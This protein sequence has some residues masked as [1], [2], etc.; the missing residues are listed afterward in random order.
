MVCGNPVK[1]VFEK[2]GHDGGEIVWP[3]NP[4]PKN[5]RGFGLNEMIMYGHRWG[6][7]F[8]PVIPAWPLTQGENDTTFFATVPEWW[9]DMMFMQHDGVLIGKHHAVA[10]DSKQQ[11]ILDPNGTKYP[12]HMFSME[13][14]WARTN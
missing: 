14:F 6:V 11:L 8:L 5:R 1:D 2:V 13:V 10:W 4:E 7:H 9:P 3:D 12:R